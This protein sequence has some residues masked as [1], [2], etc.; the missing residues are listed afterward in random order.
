MIISI[1]KLISSF[2][3]LNFS[4]IEDHI[5][6]N[7]RYAYLYVG[8]FWSITYIDYRV[9]VFS[10]GTL[11]IVV[12]LMHLSIIW[13]TGWCRRRKSCS[14][15]ITCILYIVILYTC[16]FSTR[17]AHKSL[18]NDAPLYSNIYLITPLFF[19][20]FQTMISLFKMIF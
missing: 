17:R 12:S 5:L 19:I 16:T 9:S 8:R 10:I 13:L 2:L 6:Y 4:Y 20:L 3:K 7:R 14:K 18:S 11:I 15:F 1:I